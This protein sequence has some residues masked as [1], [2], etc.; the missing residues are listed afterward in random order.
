MVKENSSRISILESSY[1][2]R[3]EFNGAL[4]RMQD[5][6]KEDY[7]NVVN[8]LHTCAARME[9]RIHQSNHDITTRLDNFLSMLIKEK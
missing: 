4:A 6:A 1:L 7:K 3:P 5:E 8:E 2:T 9:L